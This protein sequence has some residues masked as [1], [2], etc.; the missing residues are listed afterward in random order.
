MRIFILSLCLFQSLALFSQDTTGSKETKPE[1]II[2]ADET[3]KSS[4][5]VIGQS[6]ENPPNGG[7]TLLVSHHF[8][9]VNTGFYEW[10]GLDQASTRIGLEYGINDFMAVGLG[11]S[12]YDKTFDGYLK[13][14]VLH[15]SKGA[16]KMPL[17]L[18]IFG[19]MAVN[20]VKLSDPEQ[21]D[22]FDARLSYCTE[23]ILA[24]KFGKIFSLQLAP[25]WVHWNLVPTPEDNNNQFSIGAGVSF[26]VSDLISLNGEYHYMF[27]GSQM[28]NTNNS[29]SIGCDIKTGQ[30][31][32]QLFFTNSQGN[33]EQAFIT[34]TSGKWSNGY[35]YFGFNIHR[36]FTVKTPHHS[37]F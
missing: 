27:P 3:F 4:R 33:F 1:K 24:R 22:Y 12:T 17:S 8:G 13:F 20:T 7:L 14:R 35:I 29:L 2:Y 26:R 30:H 9:A 34:E 6:V 25:T 37:K 23:I 10:F 19:N 32:F 31:V 18:S 11:R 36:I 15:Q 21:T 5:V 16:R 28:E